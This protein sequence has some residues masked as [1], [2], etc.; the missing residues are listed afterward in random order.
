M[1]VKKHNCLYFPGRGRAENS[2]YILVTDREAGREMV[3][4]IREEMMDETL[5]N[6]KDMSTKDFKKE[7]IDLQKKA[8]VGRD[9]ARVEKR[10]VEKLKK[11]HQQQ[12]DFV[13]RC[14]KCNQ[15]ACV[16]SDIRSIQGQHHVVIDE[17]F[18]NRVKFVSAVKP[19]S[20]GNDGKFEKHGKIYCNK[21]YHDWGVM[22]KFAGVPI[23]IIK[24]ASFMLVDS[25][26]ERR[27]CKKWKQCPFSVSALEAE[28]LERK[29]NALQSQ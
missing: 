3:N 7:I 1:S 10:A 15:F 28:E 9:M 29:V 16:S 23:E 21:C 24:I 11:T 4:R 14:Y 25:R 27:M 22:A 2:T 19:Q 8:K 13:L 20:F 12:G 17:Q 26:D 6:I 18:C 5:R